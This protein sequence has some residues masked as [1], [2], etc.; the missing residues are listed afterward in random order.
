MKIRE[1]KKQASRRLEE[2]HQKKV[3]VTKVALWQWMLITRHGK[4][5]F[6]QYSDGGQLTFFSNP[7]EGNPW[8]KYVANL[9]PNSTF[10]RVLI[11]GRLWRSQCIDPLP[12][13]LLLDINLRHGLKN[14]RLQF[15]RD[16]AYFWEKFYG[17]ENFFTKE[18]QDIPSLIL[19]D[20]KG[21]MKNYPQEGGEWLGVARRLKEIADF[22]QIP[23]ETMESYFQKG[24][25]Q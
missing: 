4:R 6:P 12:T 11:T 19:M 16:I 25:M 14:V 3:P 24:L 13:D 2:V 7:F 21:E 1:I 22:Y 9:K 23:I 18:A 8:A 10:P 17:A 15:N 20:S 5:P